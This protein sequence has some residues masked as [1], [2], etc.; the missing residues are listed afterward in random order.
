MEEIL[1]EPERRFVSQVCRWDQKQ[2][3]F[4]KMF[5]NVLLVLGGVIAV[6]AMIYTVRNLND[7]TALWITLPGIL[8]GIV[9]ILIYS[10]GTR[11]AEER[12]LMAQILEK[13]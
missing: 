13:L 3:P 12:H 7:Q 10:M 6:S 4:Q 5:L 1:T 8:V 9:F 11:R 2:R